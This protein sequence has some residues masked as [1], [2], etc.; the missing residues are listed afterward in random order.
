MTKKQLNKRRK[1]KQ[2]ESK[3]EREKAKK[4]DKTLDNKD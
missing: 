2:V 4:A 1:L 3:L